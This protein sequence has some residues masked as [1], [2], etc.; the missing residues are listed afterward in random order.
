MYKDAA[1]PHLHESGTYKV[2]KRM[3]AKTI[4][5]KINDTW[6]MI[7]DENNFP[8]HIKKS[9]VS[10]NTDLP[11][12]Y[13]PIKTHKPQ[14]QGLKIRPIISNVN[15]PPTKSHGYSHD[16]SSL[17]FVKYPHIW[18]IVISSSTQSSHAAP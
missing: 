14:D 1:R 15:A 3:S 11:M 9:F 5:R 10:S 12:F 16:Y 18:K 17:F 13:H 4:E 6:K 2:I 7:C 8:K